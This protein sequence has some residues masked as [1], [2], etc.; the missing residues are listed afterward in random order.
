MIKGALIGKNIGYSYSKL[1]HHLLGTKYDI[2]DLDYIDESIKDVIKQYDFVNVTIPY[3]KEII[4]YVDEMDEL[5]VN[6]K[7][8]NL[9][10]NNNGILK[11]YNTDYS[12]FKEMLKY[13]NINVKNKN[14]L[15][16]GTGGASSAISLLLYE[17]K[18]NI[19]YLSR[20]NR[21]FISFGYEDLENIDIDFDII[22]NTTPIGGVNHA[23]EELI[24]F[25]VFKKKITYIDINYNPYRSSMAI[26]NEL[27][28]GTS[29]NGMIMLINQALD[30]YKYFTNDLKINRE[31]MV[32]KLYSSIYKPNI[33]LTGMMLSGKSTLGKILEKENMMKLYDIDEIIENKYGSIDKI[34]RDKSLDYF[35]KIE[36]EEI[37]SLE[38]ITNSIIVPGGGAI[39]DK[40]NLYSLK[41][42]GRLFFL[43]TELDVL[44]DRLENNNRPLT[45]TKEEFIKIYNE[46]IDK[47]N[48]YKDGTIK[49]TNG[50]YKIVI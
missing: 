11:A 35:R 42:N 43:D 26:S 21:G 12:G 40:E 45:K 46:R 47:Y 28:G 2:I 1:I 19:F 34:I 30:A 14:V 23:K 16:M 9:I 15:V 50:E 29:Y 20:T 17:L 37:L 7:A 4:K 49:Y 32:Q 41:K 8:S 6:S 36:K 5:T 39:L 48:L 38:G 24:D 44:L 33:V 10:V 3:K 31:E 18:A 22:I 25:K 13:Y 27:N